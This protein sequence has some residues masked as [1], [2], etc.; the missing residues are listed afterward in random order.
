MSLRPE[1]Y[2]LANERQLIFNVFYLTFSVYIRNLSSQTGGCQG[3]GGWE[4]DGV[5]GWG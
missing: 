5:E 1:A 4:R 2:L 3:V